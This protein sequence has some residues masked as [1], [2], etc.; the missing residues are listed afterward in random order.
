MVYFVCVVYVPTMLL[1]VPV[2]H[3]T[4]AHGNKL[5]LS[6]PDYGVILATV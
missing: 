2:P 6:E 1:H 4:C 5:G 3:S